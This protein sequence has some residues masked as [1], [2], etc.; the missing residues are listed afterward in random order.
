MCKHILIL[1][2][3]KFSAKEE[4]KKQGRQTERNKRKK[5]QDR[6]TNKNGKPTHLG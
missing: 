5:K 3:T 1:R 6:H 2:N 4:G